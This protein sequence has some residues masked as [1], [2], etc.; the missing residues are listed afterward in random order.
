V[1]AL[2]WADIRL[3][4]DLPLRLPR[5]SY[6]FNRQYNPTFNPRPF[7]SQE[8]ILA[9]NTFE[10]FNHETNRTDSFRRNSAPLFTRS[11]ASFIAD[12][13]PAAADLTP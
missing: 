1:G 2:E 5:P 8:I 13:S 9:Y 3:L 4:T 12:A 6:Y 11:A 7:E 10:E